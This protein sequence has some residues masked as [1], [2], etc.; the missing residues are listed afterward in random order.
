MFLFLNQNVCSISIPPISE[1]T[2]HIFACWVILH[3]FWHLVSCFCIKHFGPR[4]GLFCHMI[5][6]L[7]SLKLWLF[8]MQPI[9]LVCIWAWRWENLSSGFANKVADQPEHPHSLIS[10][11]VIC[12]LESIL[13]KLATDEISISYLDSVVEQACLSRTLLKPQEVLLCQGPYILA[14][15]WKHSN[16]QYQVPISG[17]KIGVCIWK[18]FFF[19]SQPKHVLSIIST[20]KSNHNKKIINCDSSLEYLQHMFW[21]SEK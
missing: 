3:V 9:H 5:S 15:D 1:I 7:F 6:N 19:I 20:I 4:S 16:Y 14:A 21:L 10:T 2:I 8:S 17:L 12:L 13:S 11:F 18:S